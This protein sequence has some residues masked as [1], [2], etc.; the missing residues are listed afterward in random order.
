MPHLIQAASDEL[1]TVRS[2]EADHETKNL[3]VTRLPRSKGLL[4]GK[5]VLFFMFFFNKKYPREQL[6]IPEKRLHARLLDVVKTT[7]WNKGYEGLLL[8]R[9][10]VA[11]EGLGLLG[12]L[13]PGK[14][15]RQ[16]GP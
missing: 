11:L 10:L 15:A 5:F 2:C 9:S 14:A 8:A 1:L 13:Q 12:V 16:L 3:R 4:S 7:P 6:S